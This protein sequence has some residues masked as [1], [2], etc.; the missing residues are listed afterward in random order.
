MRK[1]FLTRILDAKDSISSKR[2]ITLIIAS[3]FVVA[4]F[5]I[6]FLVCYVTLVLPKG[7]LD[8]RLLSSL[9]K[10]LQYDFY[11]ILS[12]LGIITSEGLLNIILN[13]GIPMPIEPTQPVEEEQPK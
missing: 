12:G 13:K 11:I 2:F 1:R 10:I 3:H 4:S 7:V 9:E 8:I 5:A 6:L